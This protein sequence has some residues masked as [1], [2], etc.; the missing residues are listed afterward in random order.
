M[1]TPPATPAAATPAAETTAARL[2]PPAVVALAGATLGAALLARDPHASGSWGYCPFL[3]LTGQPCPGCGGLR[4]T[5]DLLHGRVGDAVGS[6]L[7][8]VVTAAVA[9]LAFV[10]WTVA[11]SRGSTSAWRRHVP[12]LLAA[13]VAGL[14]VFGVARLLPG[15]DAL[16]P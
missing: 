8:A 16:R 13:W 7:Y 3:L 2:R 4:A 12:R 1:T 10:A 11:A 15:M 6:N 5:N 14:V 9:A